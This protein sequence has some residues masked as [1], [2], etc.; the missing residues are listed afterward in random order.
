[1]SDDTKICFICNQRKDLSAFEL[2]GGRK[3]ARCTAC[4]AA[5]GG[6]ELAFNL[7][8]AIFHSLISGHRTFD[9]RRRGEAKVGD[10]IR[11]SEYDADTDSYTGAV[12]YRKVGYV[13]LVTV[14]F[15]DHADHEVIGLMHQGPALQAALRIETAALRHE[16][17]EK[18]RL[19]KLASADIAYWHE[20]W[21]ALSRES[22]RPCPHGVQNPH[23]C[24]DCEDA[25]LTPEQQRVVDTWLHQ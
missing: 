19:L 15:T 23:P 8:P 9:I 13:S 12:V 24:R 20:Q 3:A 1:M 14:G 25:P 22:R 16:L 7:S 4:V 6:R 17:A 11:Y 10:L 21:M 5:H 2:V 18:D